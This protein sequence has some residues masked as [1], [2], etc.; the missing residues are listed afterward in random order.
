[1][2]MI[3]ARMCAFP[4]LAVAL[5]LAQ[6]DGLEFE[7]ASLKPAPPP[8]GSAYDEGFRAGQSSQGMIIKGNRVT[9]VDHTLTGL[10]RL[11]F[12]VK[13]YQ[14]AGE[15]WMST[16]LYQMVAT[17]P[18]GKSA[19]DAPVMLQHLLQQR[20]RLSVRRESREMNVYALLQ[21][22][23]GPKLKPAEGG[24]DGKP[25]TAG[26]LQEMVRA[27][28]GA[29]NGTPA[30]S[31]MRHIRGNLTMAALADRLTPLTDRPVL[32]LTA[33]DGAFDI[34]IAYAVDDANP[35]SNIAHAM[36]PFG[37]RLEAQKA[38]MPFIVIEKADRAPAGN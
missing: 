12:G 33:I 26:A 22:K 28:T 35:A 19:Q 18:D 23:D 8:S 15:K 2:T 11:A 17:I 29:R 32:D 30:T 7:V 1:M 38:P 36:R 16:D 34:D 25:P 20:F 13:E 10:V 24:G 31:V 3:A 37:L 6:H 9:V 14:V 5:A 27:E 4:V 21:G